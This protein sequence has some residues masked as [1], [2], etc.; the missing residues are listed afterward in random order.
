MLHLIYFERNIMAHIAQINTKIESIENAEK[1]TKVVL[2]EL[3]RE[4]L[5][6]ICL[7]TADGKASEDSQ[8][9]NRLV[10]VLTPVNKKVAIEF[11]TKI[12]PFHVTRDEEGA[13]V[14]FG[15]KDKKAWEKK[16]DYIKEFLADPHQNIWTWADRNIEIVAKPMDFAKLNQAMGQLVKKAEKANLGHSNIV[17]AL[18]ANG[19]TTDDILATL[20]AMADE[21]PKEQ[22]QSANDEQ[23]EQAA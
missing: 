17:R 8:V 22:E 5:E 19:I 15:K 4:I 9:A 18:L 2:S 21:E 13:F 1:I 23:V 12:L 10:A 7:D 3:S 16:V 14:S 20:K 6:Y 11:F